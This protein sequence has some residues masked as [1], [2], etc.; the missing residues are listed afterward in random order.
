MRIRKTRS[1]RSA[2]SAS[3]WRILAARVRYDQAAERIR[4]ERGRFE[5]FGIT[6]PLLPVFSLGTSTGGEGYSGF[7]LPELRYSRRLGGELSLPYHLRLGPNRDVT[8]TPSKR[9]QA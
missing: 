2:I 3:S 7:L 1:W 4:F 8:V 6:L 9:C 5:L